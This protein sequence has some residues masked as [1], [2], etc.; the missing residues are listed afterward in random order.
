MQR[1]NVT[2]QKDR[3][4]LD[5]R[6]VRSRMRFAAW[7]VLLLMTSCAD[8]VIPT[9][10]SWVRSARVDP[11]FE[12]RWTH[13]EKEWAVAHNRMVQAFCRDA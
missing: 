7:T 1:R 10:C 2:Q 4:M 12:Q 6:P 9:E 5:G 8:T 3:Q 11:G 13:A